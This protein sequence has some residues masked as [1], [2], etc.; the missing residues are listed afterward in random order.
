[1]APRWLFLCLSLTLSA[2]RCVS[3]DGAVFHCDEGGGCPE[4]QRCAVDPEPEAGFCIPLGVSP[5]GGPLPEGVRVLDLVFSNQNNAALD[6]FVVLVALDSAT[7][8]YALVP[9]PSTDLRFYDPDTNQDLPFQIDTWNPGGESTLWVKVPNIAA[10]STTD[11][12]TLLWGVGAGGQEDPTGHTVFDA[13]TA[14]WHLGSG[15][16]ANAARAQHAGTRTGGTSDKGKVGGALRWTGPGDQRV[17]FDSAAT[18]FDGWGAFSLEL[19]IRPDY[20]SVAALGTEGGVLD[21]GGGLN[22]GRVFRSNQQAVLQV[23]MHFTVSPNDSFLG[24]DLPLQAWTWVVYDF[25]G[26]NL[27]LYVDG[28]EAARDIY[29]A[30]TTLRRGNNPFY[31]GDNSNALLGALDEVRIAQSSHTADWVRAQHLSM[32]RAF[33]RFEPR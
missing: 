14:V 30:V 26:Q 17:T 10:N 29:S 8:D 25:D 24:T 7:I 11:R 2:C 20:A 5:D 3:F 15:P 19:W 1:M 4:G 12:I 16:V 18:L 31:L 9:N 33:I 22:L 21:K 13:W 23:D 32:T 6:G 28:V 27:V